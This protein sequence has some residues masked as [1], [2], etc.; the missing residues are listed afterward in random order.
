M[1]S[2]VI[3]LAGLTSYK[4]QAQLTQK[5]LNIIGVHQV[6]VSLEK[7]IVQITFDTPAN[8]NNIEKEIYDDGYPILF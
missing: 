8:L 6:H 3:F 2:K 1:E 5:L 7:S 4:Q